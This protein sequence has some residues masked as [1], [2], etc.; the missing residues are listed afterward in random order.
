MPVGPTSIRDKTGGARYSNRQS[1]QACLRG[2]TLEIIPTTKSERDCERQEK[3]GK[4]MGKLGAVSPTRPL[5]E[6]PHPVPIGAGVPP[7]R[8]GCSNP[9]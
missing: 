8:P 4:D 5:G 6:R 1:G 7:T 9:R 2:Q 3:L